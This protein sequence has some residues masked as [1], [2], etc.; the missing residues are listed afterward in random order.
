MN[1]K[2]EKNQMN[3][4]NQT[5]EINQ[6]NERVRVPRARRTPLPPYSSISCFFFP[7]LLSVPFH[8]LTI[9]SLCLNQISAPTSR[10]K[11][12]NSCLCSFTI[13]TIGKHVK[14]ANAPPDE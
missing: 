11:I 9:L 14:A 4:I 5:N 10:E 12:N 7:I 13:A 3:Q 8:S 6:I 1:Q 2:N